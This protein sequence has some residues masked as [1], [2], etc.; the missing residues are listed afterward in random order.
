M[1]DNKKRKSDVF[2]HFE[3]KRKT[4]VFLETTL[5]VSE[6]HFNNASAHHRLFRATKSWLNRTIKTNQIITKKRLKN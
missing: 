2:L 1:C 4:Y 3:K 5:G 6:L